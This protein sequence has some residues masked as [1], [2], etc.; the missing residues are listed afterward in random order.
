M[1]VSTD[2]VVLRSMKYG[3]TSKIVT[4]YSEKFGKIKAVA[5]GA[6]GSK[7]KYGASLEPMTH[8]SIIFYMKEQRDL[9]LLSKCEI[10]QQFLS[11]N[12][13]GDKMSAGLAVVELTNMV[14]HD[15]E[16]NGQLFR[17]LVE[18]LRSIDR[19]AKNFT[20]IFIAF[21]L[22]L[23]EILGYGLILDHC[24]RCGR[25]LVQEQKKVPVFILLASGAAVCS[26]CHSRENTGGVRMSPGAVGLMCQVMSSP[27]GSAEEYQLSPSMRDET[28]AILHTYLKYHVEGVRTLRSLSMFSSL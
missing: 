16:E 23:F 12:R 4:F 25:D 17:L 20:N 11:L 8:S 2:A 26:D 1:I 24:T 28:F 21:E 10:A 3:D 18:A 27:M 5:K 7:S 6:R 9:H 19:A 15:E 13:E 22:R 14:M